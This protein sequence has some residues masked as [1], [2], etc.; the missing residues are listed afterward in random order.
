MNIL[1]I[2]VC[3]HFSADKKICGSPREV[4]KSAMTVFR[5]IMVYN[6]AGG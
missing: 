2:S 1:G 3:Y 6:S 4:D 5:K